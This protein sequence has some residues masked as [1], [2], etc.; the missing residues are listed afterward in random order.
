MPEMIIPPSKTK[1]RKYKYPRP[2]FP[3]VKVADYANDEHLPWQRIVLAEGA[4]GPIVADVKCVRVVV[5]TSSTPYGNYL[6]PKE[7]VWLY[8]RR[9]ANGRIKYS[10]CNAPEDTPMEVLN[11]VA[12]MR[13]PIEQCFE[14]CKSHLGMGH[15]EARS[16]KAWHRHMLFVMMAHLFTQ[17]LHIH[18]KKNDSIDHADG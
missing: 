1:G 13:W 8:I 10:L 2:S 17:M 7:A 3:P 9:Y 18:F 15:V 14:E 12:T 11:R 5:C 4:K 6:V 16:Y